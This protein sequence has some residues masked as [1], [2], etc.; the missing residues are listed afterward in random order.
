MHKNDPNEKETQNLVENNRFE[1]KNETR[2]QAQS[3]PKS[4][5]NLTV[6]RCI[7]GT[8]LEILTSF[9]GDL[10]RKQTHKLKMG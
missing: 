3:I 9:D 7:V 5:R 4:I 6:L 2:D 1:I 10:W 8:N